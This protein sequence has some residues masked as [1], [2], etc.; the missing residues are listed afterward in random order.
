MSAI[1]LAKHAASPA[2]SIEA[3][4]AVSIDSGDGAVALE[5]GHG[6]VGTPTIAAIT[7][8]AL[9]YLGIGCAVHLSGPAGTGKTTPGEPRRPGL[10]L[11][12]PR[13]PRRI[14]APGHLR[15]CGRLYQRTYPP[16]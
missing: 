11:G 4:A 9:T 15:Q 7:E 1:P 5:P 14:G 2:A 16:R 3:A 10:C 13:H 6:F 12:L 8:R